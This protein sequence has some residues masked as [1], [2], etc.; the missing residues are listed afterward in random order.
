[1]NAVRIMQRR[2]VVLVATLREA[3]MENRANEPVANLQ[4]ALSYGALCNYFQQRA[5]LLETLHA[6]RIYTVDETAQNLPVAL[7]NQYLDL[8]AAGRI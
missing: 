8:K 1:M 3:E 4:D 5:H 6:N 7:A 2:H